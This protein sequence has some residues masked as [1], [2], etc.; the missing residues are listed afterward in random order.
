MLAHHLIRQ[1]II[2]PVAMVIPM[3]LSPFVPGFDSFA[4]HLSEYQLGPEW[5]SAIVRISAALAG[6]SII[7]FSIG[8]LL[9]KGGISWSWSALAGFAFGLAMLFNGIFVAGDPR[10][11][12]YGLAI[13]AVL[14]PAFFATEF[15]DWL[16]PVGKQISLFVAFAGLFYMWF[17]LVGLDPAEYRGLTQRAYILLS[18]GWFLVPFMAAGRQRTA[19]PVSS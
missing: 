13:F 16:T 11:G 8:L 7:A 15:S 5:I 6:T 9:A 17:L 4:S 1:G 12:L 19:S 18:F 2:A 14:L 3:L 10:H